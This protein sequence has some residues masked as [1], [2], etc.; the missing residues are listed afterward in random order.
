[1][2]HTRPQTRIYRYSTAQLEIVRH[3]KTEEIIHS[4]AKTGNITILKYLLN[5]YPLVFY[6][7]VDALGNNILQ[8]VAS[9]CS[10][11]TLQQLLEAPFSFNLQH[12]NK[13]GQTLIFSVVKGNNV[14]VLT[15]LASFFIPTLEELDGDGNN[16]ALIA[17]LSSH[18]EIL[19]KIEQLKPNTLHKINNAGCNITMLAAWSN[20]VD[21]LRWVTDGKRFGKESLKHKDKEGRNSLCV[22]TYQGNLL[23]Q[24]TIVEMLGVDC[25]NEKIG[26]SDSNH[27]FFN[28]AFIAAARGHLDFLEYLKSLGADILFA[29]NSRGIGILSAALNHG[30]LMVADWL[31]AD[32]K[33]SIDSIPEN[34]HRFLVLAA[35]KRGDKN[36]LLWLSKHRQ[37]PFQY[38]IPDIMSFIADL[39][40]IELFKWGYSQIQEYKSPD[41]E[42]LIRR[43]YV[44]KDTLF[45]LIIFE[46]LFIY[47]YKAKCTSLFI[48][49]V[50]NKWRLSN[51][52]MQHQIGCAYSSIL[53]RIHAKG[54]LKTA[55]DILDSH[56]RLT[57][58]VMARLYLNIKSSDKSIHNSVLLLRSQHSPL[59]DE[60][61]ALDENK[62]VA[63]IAYELIKNSILPSVNDLK[64]YIHQII[65]NDQLSNLQLTEKN[66][67]QSIKL[68]FTLY[69]YYLKNKN[70]ADA[71]SDDFFIESM[72]TET[73]LPK[74]EE[75][76][77]EAIVS[78]LGD[79]NDDF[80][81]KLTETSSAPSTPKRDREE[82]FPDEL[83]PNKQPR[84][85]EE[86]EKETEDASTLSRE[87]TVVDSTFSLSFFRSCEGKENEEPTKTRRE[88]D[89]FASYFMQRSTYP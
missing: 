11:D 70:N 8:I 40:K 48:N 19:Q 35:I 78:F 67:P 10:P 41:V 3:N 71:I 27:A 45:F 47:S 76:Q 66:W 24:Q 39:H 74:I 54:D 52:E 80:S 26:H 34:V 22:A 73:I 64:I 25:L 12:K 55:K 72:I 46:C 33:I 49:L 1:M 88:D 17:A 14:E 62:K 86:K 32:L 69:N 63:L 23:M 87:S 31:L 50:E 89:E 13:D 68:L 58:E 82:D 43:M 20:N 79:L 84:V 75:E 7:T 29:T 56:C 57:P 2:M 15:K 85:E 44:D 28:F 65:C 4:A 81:Q 42:Q 77:C 9:H 59:E 53:Y 37:L 5:T 21:L 18:I 6:T 61:I 16:P 83:P 30:K 38:L 36:T 60:R 51:V